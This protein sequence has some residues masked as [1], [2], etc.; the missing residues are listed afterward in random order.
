M[1]IRLGIVVLAVQIMTFKAHA[2]EVLGSL[3]IPTEMTAQLAASGCRHNGSTFKC[4]EFVSNTDGD[5]LRVNIPGVHPLL[6]KN[7]AIRLRGVN[8]PEIGRSKTACEREAGIRAK[9]EVKRIMA[10]AEYVELRNYKRGSF[11]RI[12]ADVIVDGKSLSEHLLKNKYGVI[13]Q[14]NAPKVEWCTYY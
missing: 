7:A 1:L 14:K 2:A 9:L 11:F 6:G 12:V 13:Y 5:T 3:D 10:D 8:T 4:V